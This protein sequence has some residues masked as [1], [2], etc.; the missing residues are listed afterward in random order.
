MQIGYRYGEKLMRVDR[1]NSVGHW[2]NNQLEKNV[3][4]K[5]MG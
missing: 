5:E 4:S 2:S 1:V 3:E